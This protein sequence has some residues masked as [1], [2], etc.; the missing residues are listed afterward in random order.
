MVKR[1]VLLICSAI[2]GCNSPEV[3]SKV[4][5]SLEFAEGGKEIGVNVDVSPKSR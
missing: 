1:I 4:A 2:Y 5:V 3:N